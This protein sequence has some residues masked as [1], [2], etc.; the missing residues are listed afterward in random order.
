MKNCK[1]YLLFFLLFTAFSLTVNAAT[2]SLKGKRISS[3][4]GLLCNGVN[5]IIQDHNGYIW[6][7]TSNG[8]S[9]YDGYSTVNFR[10][11]SNDPKRKTDS[12]IGRLFI[13]T[14]NNLLWIRTAT[15]I[16]AC[17]DLS[18][19]KFVD[20]TGCGD[21]FRYMTRNYQSTKGM[22][23]YSNN[24]GARFVGYNKGSFYHKDFNKSNRLL[25]SNNAR[26]IIEDNHHHI[27][28]ATDKGIVMVTSEDK[29]KTLDHKSNILSATTK[30]GLIYFVT[31][32]NR[33]MVF[34]DGGKMIRNSR[35]PSALGYV[36]KV[37][38][39]F[40]WQGKLMIFAEDG[41]YTM[42]IKS[43]TVAK[44]QQNQI[45]NG[46]YQ[47]SVEGYNFVSN[48]SGTLWMFPDKGEMRVLRLINDAQFT[49]NKKHKYNIARDK[50]GLLYIATYGNGLFTYNPHDN[51]LGHYTAEDE[52]PLI[53]SNYL[54]S[55]M[56]DRSGC[57]WT[58]SDIAGAS[59]IS[60]VNGATAEYIL[61]EPKRKGDWSNNIVRII[62]QGE[63]S[64]LICNKVNNIY[65]Y[66]TKDKSLKLEKRMNASVRGYITDKEGHTWIGTYGDGLYVDG[67]HYGSKEKVNR[68]PADLIVDMRMDDSGRIWIATWN[69]GLLMTRYEK[70]RPLTFKQFLCK[71]LNES[72]IR[73]M[74]FGR[75]GELWIASDKGI[76]MVNTHL[77]DIT[78]SSFRYYYTENGKFPNDE[79]ICLYYSRKDQLWV[80][81]PGMGVMRCKVS[82]DRQRISYDII[83]SRKGL[84]NDNVNSITE[85][86]NGH[87]WVGTE[88]GAS[89]LNVE[90]NWIKSYRFTSYLQGN[91]YNEASVIAAGDG[92]LY[93]GT[94][95]G[96]AVVTPA[97]EKNKNA[98][99]QV[100]ITDLKINGVSIY[101][102]SNDH[103]INEDIAFDKKV[104]LAHNQ[105]SLSISFSNFDYAD[106]SSALY[107]YYLE[108]MDSTWHPL[109]S[110]NHADYSNIRPGRYIL[111][112][113]SFN[114]RNDSETSLIIIIH[115]PW[116]NTWWAWT[117]YLL[118]VCG[119]TLY[120]YRNWREKFELHQ[121]MQLEKQ[122]TEFRLNFFTHIAHEFRTPL[123]IIQGAVDNIAQTERTE[124][125]KSAI[126]TAKRGTKRLFKLINQL[127]D[128]R[129]VNTGNMKLQV[130]KDDIIDFIRNVYMDFWDISKQKE[131]QF[132]FTPFEKRHEMRFDKQ[133]VETIVYNLISNAMKYTPAK[134]CIQLKIDID[135]K[136]ENIIITCED[137]GPGIS[138]LQM[139]ELFKPFMHGYA[140]QGGMGIGLYTAHT[141]A[142]LHK[143]SLTYRKTDGHG[144]SLF[145]LTLSVDESVYEADDYKTLT[146]INNSKEEEKDIEII[147]E[148]KPMAFN[149]LTVTI[150][151]DDPDMME[152]IR[153]EM[154]I[155]FNV[156]GYMDGKS[157][158]EGVIK[159]QPSLVICDVMLPDMNGY[160]VVK[161]IKKDNSTFGI[162]VI[163][164]TALDDD[165][166]QIK[167]YEAGADDY[168]VKP[169][170]FKVL[171]A[172]VCQLIKWSQR[173]NKFAEET[174]EDENK[175]VSS[176]KVITNRTD[177]RFKENIENIVSQHLGDPNFTIDQLSA[178]LNMGRTKFYGKM[179]ELTGMPPN[180]Y[181]TNERMKVAEELLKET[182]LNVA[183][184]GYKVGFYDTSYFNKCFKARYGMAPS[185]YRKAK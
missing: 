64:L 179:K 83:D 61:P 84:V 56:I 167:G 172:R 120:I 35:I 95:H 102:N 65:R 18:K 7:G 3:V 139:N 101:Q 86:A 130:E 124:V 81:A 54:M 4:D 94:S 115:E 47:G 122:L 155:Y 28:I 145:T 39:S 106:I 57:V 62:R 163:M 133:I 73:N 33:I 140:S 52:N 142:E 29:I 13:D 36:N 153:K 11:L 127:M 178:M 107:K 85:D 156:E 149:N 174:T 134:G 166:H 119:I 175:Q 162:P 75:N 16:N 63:S 116:Y 67:I 110:V 161:E 68:F 137:N 42:D 21:N 22:W 121:Q 168:M 176:T 180:K 34:N 31:S 128:F 26:I 123:A 151:E 183:E 50:S 14:R 23:L 109:T 37:N 147:R 40:V 93:F 45:T 89:E 132:I 157:G 146:A 108:G 59:C 69:G 48:S 49:N 92:R 129:K 12:H 135:S 104:S 144:G 114:S 154:S 164:L 25:P 96:M 78:N 82:N 58:G 113:R 98:D 182:D 5:E 170:N 177:L 19:A 27:W 91:V 79:I 160:D 6:M 51:T 158:Y 60:P 97:G 32:D 43:G 1:T 152:Q 30:D 24:Y 141:M 46:L 10:S 117:I 90:N 165:I 181:L 184:V 41:T 171:I 9:R 88:E 136:T 53:Y 20:Y 80:S 17:Y 103:E 70:N 71:D 72:D 159:K 105:N 131:M 185:K 8:L 111:H 150:I 55:I 138:D 38:T 74:T 15:F 99:M 66:S 112:I 76:I 87:I 100:H 143:G 44:P 148:M 2:L 126:Q 173:I 169:C 118:A 125:P 77:K